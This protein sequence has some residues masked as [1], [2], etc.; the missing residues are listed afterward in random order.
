MSVGAV[1][2][3]EAV[4]ALRLETAKTMNKNIVRCI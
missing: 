4:L 1:L 2:M 3:G